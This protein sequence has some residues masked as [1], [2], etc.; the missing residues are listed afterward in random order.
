M[1][2]RGRHYSGITRTPSLCVQSVLHCSKMYETPIL[3]VFSIS[4]PVAVTA[5]LHSNVLI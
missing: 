5:N 2:G 1:E 4:T 3:H